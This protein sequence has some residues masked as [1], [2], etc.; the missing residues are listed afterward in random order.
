VIVLTREEKEKL[1]QEHTL[2]KYDDKIFSRLFKYN[3]SDVWLFIMGS[4]GALLN[5]AIYPVFSLFLAR[6][7]EIL[8]YLQIGFGKYNINDANLQALIFLIIGIASFIFSVM[9]TYAFTIIGDRLT[10]KIRV[11]CYRKM[12]KM[13][14]AWFDVP[15]NNAGNL[16]ARLAN[17]CQVVNGLT[18]NLVGTGIQTVSCLVTGIV[19]AF[20]YDWRTSLVTLG[21]MP[22]MILSGYI[23]M[24]FMV[25]FSE[26]SDEAYKDSS[27]IIMETLTNIRT[28]TSFGVENSIAS[29]YNEKLIAPFNLAKTRGN[30]AGILYGI[31]KFTMFLVFA[32]VFYTGALFVRD[33]GVNF[34]DVFTAIFAIMFAAIRVGNN[35]QFM[36]DVAAS[37]NSAAS[38]FEIID[39]EDE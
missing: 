24:K 37:K 8:T 17:D 2:K 14:V 39:G 29:N 36:P 5:G 21:L 11:E 6:M 19:I 22:L 4:I 9:Q 16:T 27:S 35:S 25:G 15:K 12:L 28:V 10:K 18:S 32:L 3:R 26:K 34:G 23:N 13:P 33:D 1:E 31:S 7:I 38:L 20:A 30:L